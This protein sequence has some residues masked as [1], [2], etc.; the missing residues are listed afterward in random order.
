[1]KI[2]LRQGSAW[3]LTALLGLSAAAASACAAW[4]ALG[5]AAAWQHRK[6]LTSSCSSCWLDSHAPTTSKL[7]Q[8]NLDTIWL[9]RGVKL[10]ASQMVGLDDLPITSSESEFTASSGGEDVYELY[11]WFSRMGV[12]HLKSSSRKLSCHHCK[13]KH[14]VILMCSN[15][16][17]SIKTERELVFCYCKGTRRHINRMNTICTLFILKQTKLQQN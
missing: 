5:S 14:S 9:Y 17:M 7:T 6:T 15:F 8:T 3:S 10:V 12:D 16:L 2:L 11:E 13:Y 4:F 1:M